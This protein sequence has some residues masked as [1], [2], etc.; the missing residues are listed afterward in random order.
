MTLTPAPA[1]H[2][3]VTSGPVAGSAARVT[4][5]ASGVSGGI[6]ARRSTPSISYE[7][8]IDQ[9]ETRRIGAIGVVVGN[10]GKLQ[11]G[12]T[13]LPDADPSDGI[14]DVIFLQPRRWADVVKLAW[15][16]LRRRPDAGSQAEVLRGKR[17]TIRAARAVPSEFDGEYAGESDSLT[18]AVLPRAVTV[19]A[20]P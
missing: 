14:L 11:G 19:C 7:V 9:Q 17:V 2:V 6:R 18:A 4:L 3:A 5:G 12:V 10:V 16:V 1:I 20:A 15:D 13:L 8:T